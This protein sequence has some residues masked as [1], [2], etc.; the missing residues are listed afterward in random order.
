[1]CLAVSLPYL[2]ID[3]GGLAAPAPCCFVCI[4]IGVRSWFELLFET[5]FAHM[6]LVTVLA[7]SGPKFY[8]IVG[9]P[10]RFN[11]VSSFV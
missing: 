6:I 5:L 7:V 2:D 8:L 11:S 9:S 1:M 4:M 3:T 10:F